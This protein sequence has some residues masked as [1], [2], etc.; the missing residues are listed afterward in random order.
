MTGAG[1]IDSG[2]A[3]IVL[4]VATNNS[5]ITVGGVEV[6]DGKAWNEECWEKLA[7][8]RDDVGLKM[9]L[10]FCFAIVQVCV[11]V[12]K[13]ISTM[14]KNKDHIPFCGK[15]EE[16]PQEDGLA[17]VVQSSSSDLSGEVNM[18]SSQWVTNGDGG[19][20]NATKPKPATNP[21]YALYGLNEKLA[22]WMMLVGAILMM[23]SGALIIEGFNGHDIK[24]DDSLTD[25]NLFKYGVVLSL[26]CACFVGAY[27]LWMI[28]AEVKGKKNPETAEYKQFVIKTKV[29][30]MIFFV[31]SLASFIMIL[32][33]AWAFTWDPKCAPK[34][35][36]IM[37]K[38]H[39]LCNEQVCNEQIP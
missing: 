35:M 17:T 14:W 27:T 9:K 33:N 8:I 16:T 20:T 24:T 7:P 12:A 1:I 21:E 25:F 15:K 26:V 36:D 39:K 32:T 2:W 10:I 13:F 4:R 28:Y 23:T 3:N 37:N 22:N 18:D 29:M 38:Y 31:L 19:N 11:G 34:M 6:N 5:K 30:A